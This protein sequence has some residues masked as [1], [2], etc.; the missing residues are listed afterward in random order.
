[1]ALKNQVPEYASAIDAVVGYHR[2]QP[3]ADEWGSMETNASGKAVPEV[4]P[5]YS[6]LVVNGGAVNGCSVDSYGAI[7]TGRYNKLGIRRYIRFR[8]ESEG[9]YAVSATLTSVPPDKQAW[10]VLRLRTAGRD[11]GGD[12]KQCS[13]SELGSC[14]LTTVLD[15]VS[16]GDNVLV[17][18]DE[19]NAQ[20]ADPNRGRKCFDVEITRR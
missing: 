4:L 9:E 15:G 17:L 8:A 10:P 19:G 11:G 16:A 5:V 12:S 2:I 14:V 1:M 7:R 20:M 6:E 3:I 18:W 13:R